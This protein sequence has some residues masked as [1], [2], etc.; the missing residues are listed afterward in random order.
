MTDERARDTA[1]VAGFVRR[2]RRVALHLLA[3]DDG[4][5]EE[6]PIPTQNVELTECS[7]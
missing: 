2:L 5:G 6:K 4:V 1:L 3:L 7:N